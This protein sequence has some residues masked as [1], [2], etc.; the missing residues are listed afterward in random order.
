MIIKGGSRSAPSQLGRHLLRADTNERVEIL[1]L[2]SPTGDL[3]EALRDWQFLADGTR[4]T[5]GLYHANIDPDSRYGMTPE[6]WKR[7]VD[8]LEEKLGFQ[9]QP[10]AIVMHE[11]HGRQHIHVVW[12]RTDIDT[13]TLRS[14]SHNYLKHEEASLAL[15]LEFGHEHVPGKH[16]K[17]DREK[18]PE[19]PRAELTHAEWQQAE[20]AA[21][22]PADRK[23]QITDLFRQCDNGQAFKAALVD[24]GYILAQGD[25]RDY[26][27]VDPDG[28]IHSLGRQI[29]GIKAKELRE[30]MADID[31]ETLPTVDQAK[32]LQQDAAQKQQPEAREQPLTQERLQPP[33]PEED[34]YH[35]PA[36]EEIEAIEPIPT[37]TGEEDQYH[38]LSREEIEALEQALAERHATE[39]RR[40]TE[41]QQAELAHLRG[42]IDRENVEKLADTD[43]LQAAERARRHREIYPERTG[44]AGF[45][46]AIRER[47]NPEAAA[48]IKAERDRQW[49]ALLARQEEQRAA[50]LD[51]LAEAREQDAADLAERHA[52]RLR[53][54]KVRSEDDLDRYVLEGEAARRLLAAEQER[55]RQ[56]A[57]E[58]ARGRD[59]PDPPAPTR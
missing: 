53:E 7:A 2:Q 1:E 31:R 21:I 11:K 23:E 14:D 55:R 41:A 15:E 56:I 24:E 27:L 38:R 45:I 52:Q 40:L 59:G 49:Q 39:A 57:E 6:Q 4:G 44:F 51:S 28:E 25:R 36:R 20:R 12:Q 48:E 32:T 8:V 33:A 46:E 13:M 17:R 34:E 5:K 42:I 29:K 47:F 19:F 58:Q 54:L 26:V 37:P 30:F 10:R 16:A 9:G 50:R 35:R 3:N 22:D 18:Q 43:A